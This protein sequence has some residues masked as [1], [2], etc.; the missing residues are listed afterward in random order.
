MSFGSFFNHSTSCPMSCITLSC[1]NLWVF[2]PATF[3]SPECLPE[4]LAFHFLIWPPSSTWQ[5]ASFYC[6]T[7]PWKAL[8]WSQPHHFMWYPYSI[9]HLFSCCVAFLAMCR[10][11]DIV[12]ASLPEVFNLFW[13]RVFHMAEN[14]ERL[15]KFCLEKNSKI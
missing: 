8:A 11:R 12:L 14:W 3:L 10:K 7:V 15:L 1:A 6:Q 5:L 2:I 4:L 9:C 13:Y